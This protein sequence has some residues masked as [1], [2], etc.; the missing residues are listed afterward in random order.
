MVVLRLLCWTHPTVCYCHSRHRV[1]LE[2]QDA[3]RYEGIAVICR[4]SVS[5]RARH[6]PRAGRPLLVDVSQGALGRFH[7]TNN[8]ILYTPQIPIPA[9]QRLLNDTYLINRSPTCALEP[10]KRFPILEAPGFQGRHRTMLDQPGRSAPVSHRP[11]FNQPCTLVSC[12]ICA[13]F[14]LTR[15]SRPCPHPEQTTAPSRPFRPNALS[16]T[17]TLC[18]H[19]L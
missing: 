11:S 9:T 18:P 14:R 12:S 19:S 7:N 10:E 17:P 8:G 15:T 16:S 13:S 4:R 6:L 5:G 2:C 3:E 1:S